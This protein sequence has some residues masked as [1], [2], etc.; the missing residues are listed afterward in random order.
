MLLDSSAAN[1][2]RMFIAFAVVG[3]VVGGGLGWLLG[4]KQFRHTYWRLDPEGL[5]LRRGRMWLRETRVPI[6]RVQHLDLKRGPLQRRRSL[7]TLVV[8]TAGTRNSSVVVPNIDVD[9]AEF[10]RDRLGRQIDLDHD[11]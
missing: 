4:H 11:D 9:D 1:A 8:H 6:T 10:L 5:A 3:L 2:L 7:A